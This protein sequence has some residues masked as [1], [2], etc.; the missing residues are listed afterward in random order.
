MAL[1]TN[2]GLFPWIYG[3]SR[4]APPSNE[5]IARV[6]VATLMNPALHNGKSYRPTG[7]RLLGAKEMAEAISRAIGHRVRAVPVPAALFM[8]SARIAGVPIE[9]LSNVRYY[10]EDHKQGAFELCAPTSDVFELTGR[11]PEDFETIATRY[12]AQ[13]HN[14]RTLRNWFR[15]CA[16]FMLAPFVPGFNFDRYDRE[17]RRPFPSAPRYA[18][19]SAIWRDEHE[20]TDGIQPVAPIQ[21]NLQAAV[22]GRSQAGV[23]PSK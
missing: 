14:Q 4:N 6:A 2:L 15:Q 8:K 23:F 20:L 22:P 21:K 19:E 9:I 10:I 16:L 5:D 1:A 7:P 13:P 18:V 11:H 12:A 17:L 3:D